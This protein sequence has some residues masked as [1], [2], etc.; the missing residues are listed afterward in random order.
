MARLPSKDRK[1]IQL[2]RIENEKERAVTLS[3]WCNGIFKKANELAT[4]CHIQIAIIL[5]SIT[6]K[7]LSFGSPNVQ[8]VVNKFLNPNQLDQQ[9]NDF[10]NMAVN[11]NHESKLQDFNKEFDEV[12]EHLA[13]E[14]K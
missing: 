5:F 10:I 9:P 3:K 11:S 8:S 6:G 1:K 4:L 14:K 12:N 13:N 2:E 7:R